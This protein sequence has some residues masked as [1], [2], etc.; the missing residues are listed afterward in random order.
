ME[1]LTKDEIAKI[2]LNAHRG[3]QPIGSENTLPGF[4][5]AGQL[6][7]TF[8]ETDVWMTKDGHLVCIHENDISH[9]IVNIGLHFFLKNVR[10]MLPPVTKHNTAVA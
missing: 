2:R 3:Y 7:F 9:D 8:I 1:T 6:G 10:P 4:I 5:A